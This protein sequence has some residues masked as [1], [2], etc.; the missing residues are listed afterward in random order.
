MLIYHYLHELVD[1]Y[2]DKMAAARFVMLVYA[3]PFVF[4]GSLAVGISLIAGAFNT[5]AMTFA[6]LA[7]VFCT[8]YLVELAMYLYYLLRCNQLTARI[9]RIDNINSQL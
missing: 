9:E 6:V 7:G 4:F 1:E 5:S 3:T 2:R 8:L